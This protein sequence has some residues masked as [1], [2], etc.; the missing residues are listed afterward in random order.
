MKKITTLCCA[1]LIAL[2]S[3][4]GMASC[5]KQNS[6]GGDGTINIT[7]DVNVKADLK[8]SCSASQQEMDIITGLGAA[9]KKYYPNVTV[10]PE[11]IGGN[12]AIS[13][14]MGWYRANAMPDILQLSSYEMLNLKNA[15]VLL[16]LQP[17]IDAEQTAGSFNVADFYESY[18][19]LGQSVFNGDQYLIP[20]SADTV[21]CQVNKRILADAGVDL[22]PE[23]TLVKNGWTWEDFLT[24]CAQVKQKYPNRGVVDSYYNWEAIFNPIFCSFGAEYIK[25]GKPAID[26][27]GTRKALELI[28]DMIDKGYQGTSSSVQ[29]NFA[30]GQGAFMFHSQAISIGKM[31]MDLAMKKDYPDGVDSSVY[32]VVT[33]PIINEENPCVG[34]GIAGYAVSSLT[35]NGDIAW[36]FLKFMTSKEGQNAIADQKTN[37]PPIRKDMSDITDSSNHWTNGYEQFN[38]EAYLWAAKNNA[39]CMTKFILANPSVSSDLISA[40]VTLISDYAVTGDTM[41]ESLAECNKK[42]T[43]WLNN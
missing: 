4:F 29:A 37:Y 22:N 19:Q 3:M 42:L 20:R 14:V 30:G 43:Y 9:F 7:P 36:Q 18:W 16:N 35:K 11:P 24:V 13:T 8:I 27:E 21:V 25:D 26:N 2:C 41:E 28:K 5:G 38:L 31:N 1:V 40:V 15:G 32:D 12:N 10:T 33:F 39:L 17:Y 23:T 34:A 6:G